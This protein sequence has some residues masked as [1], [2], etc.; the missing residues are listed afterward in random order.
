MGSMED[1]VVLI[2]GGTSG[3]GLAAA[4]AFARAGASIVSLRELPGLP[5]LEQLFTPGVRHRQRP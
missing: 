1:K 3:I 2:T 5:L 4:G